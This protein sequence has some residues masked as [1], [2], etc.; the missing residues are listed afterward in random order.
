[1]GNEKLVVIAFTKEEVLGLRSARAY[2]TVFL[3]LFSSE[4]V[5]FASFDSR[6]FRPSKAASNS[7]SFPAARRCSSSSGPMMITGN[8]DDAAGA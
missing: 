4:D 5:G 7:G 2:H 3:S 6:A 1:M 8:C